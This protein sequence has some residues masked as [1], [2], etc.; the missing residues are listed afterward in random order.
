MFIEGKQI[1]AEEKISVRIDYKL[2]II[3]LLKYLLI[4]LK[5]SPNS[6]SMTELFP[7]PFYEIISDKCILLCK[8]KS[9]LRVHFISFQVYNTWVT[10]PVKFSNTFSILAGTEHWISEK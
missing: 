8:V 9:S 7:L 3:I 4:I 2:Y 10:A 5:K 1:K 6:T